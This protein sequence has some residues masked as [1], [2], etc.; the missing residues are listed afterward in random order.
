MI[1]R[2]GFAWPDDV[3]HRDEHAL[4][5]VQ[6]LE[7]GIRFC[8]H[9]RTAVQ[10]GGNIGLWPARLAQVF[11]RVLTFEPDTASRACLEL[12]VPKN[13]LISPAALGRAEGIC[14]WKHKGLGSH[15][16]VED[17]TAS[18]FLTTVDALKIDDL[19]FLQLDVEGYEAAALEGARETIARCHPVIQLELRN[20]TEKFGSSDDEVRDFL[21]ALGYRQV[22]RAQGSDFI[23]T[24]R[25]A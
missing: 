24:W 12:N 5:H 23:F 11:A 22:A 6:S 14:G 7:I 13:V 9:F 20:F 18:V 21:S 19:D 1:H 15:R 2:H 25:A 3:G 8:H 16:V 4:M 17:G 10:A